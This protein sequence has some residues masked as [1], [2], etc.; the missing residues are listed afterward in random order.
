MVSDCGGDAKL[1]S[2]GTISFG[3]GEKKRNWAE[4]IGNERASERASRIDRHTV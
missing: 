1:V 2:V 3:A 4:M